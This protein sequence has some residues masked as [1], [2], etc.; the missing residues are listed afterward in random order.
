[1]STTD[2]GVAQLLSYVVGGKALGVPLLRVKGILPYRGAR[3]LAGAPPF[4]RGVVPVQGTAVPV[5]DL[6]AA[7][8][9][10][11]A[12]TTRSCVLLVEPAAGRGTLTLGVLADAVNDVVELGPR[13]IGPPPLRE[14]GIAVPH[15]HGVATVHGRSHVLLD[16]DGV[17]G[18]LRSQPSAG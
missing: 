17:L 7:L 6:A 10:K 9:M 16:L 11:A 8:G 4:I 2:T 13:D 3:A 15:V 18:A 14:D 5:V 1:M 12:T